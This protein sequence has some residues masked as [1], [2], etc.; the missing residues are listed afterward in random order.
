MK[1]NEE[2]ET[3]GF[4]VLGRMMAEEIPK[5]ALEQARGGKATKTTLEPEVWDVGP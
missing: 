1:K 4:R 5:A 3:K 2:K